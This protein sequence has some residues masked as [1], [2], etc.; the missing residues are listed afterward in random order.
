MCTLE[1]L[2]PDRRKQSGAKLCVACAAKLMKHAARPENELIA[3][4]SPRVGFG[5]SNP[6][7]EA[8]VRA[9]RHLTTQLPL[10]KFTNSL[11]MPREAEAGGEHTTVCVCNIT[12]THTHTHTRTREVI[13]RSTRRAIGPD[14]AVSVRVSV[15]V[16]VFLFRPRVPA[17][18]R[19]IICPTA[20]RRQ[21][22]RRRRRRRRR[23]ISRK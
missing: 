4:R 3:V 9:H 6:S 10:E 19:L 1:N 5:V 20:K 14:A 13:K 18:Q 2:S 12:H 7:V 23:G 22:R 16:C 21:R 17:R 8:Y 15:C 11:R